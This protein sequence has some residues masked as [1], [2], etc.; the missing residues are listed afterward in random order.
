MSGRTLR[1]WWEQMELNHLVCTTSDLQSGTLPLG[2]TPIR[3]GKE[4]RTP[5]F[6]L[7]R[8]ARFLTASSRNNR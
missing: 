3:S 6:E 2:H 5:D 1:T 8:L 4:I 7:M